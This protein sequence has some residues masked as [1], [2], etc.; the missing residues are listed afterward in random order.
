MMK[1]WWGYAMGYIVWQLDVFG[2]QF[3]TWS[4][5]ECARWTHHSHWFLLAV[6]G[7]GAYVG[8]DLQEI[9]FS[10]LDLKTL[11]SQTTWNGLAQL[12]R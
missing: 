2:I 10:I 4:N 11:I 9:M 3:L 1:T 5:A 8:I 6:N 7:E 12:P